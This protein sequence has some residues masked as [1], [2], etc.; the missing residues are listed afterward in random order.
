MWNFPQHW[1]AQITLPTAGS[2]VRVLVKSFL[3]GRKIVLFRFSA[4]ER[5]S[6]EHRKFP[7]SVKGML[8]HSLPKWRP[9]C[10][11]RS[12]ESKAKYISI[13]LIPIP[14]LMKTRNVMLRNK[15]WVFLV[16]KLDAFRVGRKTTK[17]Q[18]MWT[19]GW[20]ADCLGRWVKK[21]LVLPWLV[22]LLTWSSKYLCCTGLSSVVTSQVFVDFMSCL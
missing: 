7:W 4:G 20:S 17:E 3:S 21:S 15:L 14:I 18:W 1:Q 6:S 19:N 12:G 8:C 16:C 13:Y 5:K 9:V 11:W 22:E 10:A 2:G